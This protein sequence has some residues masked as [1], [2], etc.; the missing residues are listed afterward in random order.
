MDRYEPVLELEKIQVCVNVRRNFDEEKLQELGDSIRE[1]GLLEPLIV[2]PGEGGAFLLVAGER[3]LRAARLAGLS[4]V[5]ARVLEMDEKTATKFQLLENLQ[6]EDLDPVEEAEAFRRLIQEHGYTQEVLARELGISQPHVSNRL[7]LLHLPDEVQ[8][9]ITRRMLSPSHA[10]P[11]VPVAKVAPDL[12]LAAA[13]KMVK[14]STPSAEAA[15]V[16]ERLVSEKLP[17]LYSSNWISGDREAPL[18][19]VGPCQ[20]CK[21]VLRAAYWSNEKKHPYCGNPECWHGKQAEARDA[22]A[23]KHG[24]DKVVNAAELPYGSFAHFDRDNDLQGAWELCA[25][26]G[27]RKMTAYGGAVCLDPACYGKTERKATREKNAGARGR[28][29]EEVQRV[30]DAAT[31]VAVRAAQGVDHGF[32]VYAAA[33]ALAAVNP[34]YW[35]DNMDR[36]PGQAQYATTVP[37]LKGADLSIADILNARRYCRERAKESWARVLGCLDG[38]S[39]AELALIAVEYPALARGISP[40]SGW[41]LD[42]EMED[43]AENGEADSQGQQGDA[44]EE[45]GKVLAEVGI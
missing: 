42:I 32:M 23:T 22:M 19:D 8:E 34:E 38:L 37:G 14:Q 33:L 25:N 28:H 35:D 36:R 24:A 4:T 1:N 39:D 29:A 3:R 7:R 13:E 11:L 40:L 12:A 45:L 27:K 5:P 9:S 26:C 10:V 21:S 16:V 15:D 43:V 17:P 44:E 6:R 41:I 30:R 2:R 18:F 31:A 20:N